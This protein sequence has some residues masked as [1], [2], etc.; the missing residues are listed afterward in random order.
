MN[1][2]SRRL[3]DD[4]ESYQ[5]SKKSTDGPLTTVNIVENVTRLAEKL[6][7][8]LETSSKCLPWRVLGKSKNGVSE[9]EQMVFYCADH[10]LIRKLPSG[11]IETFPTAADICQSL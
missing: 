2:T 9:S 10:H 3:Y 11:Y 6:L 8:M 7:K 4:M 5:R 1:T